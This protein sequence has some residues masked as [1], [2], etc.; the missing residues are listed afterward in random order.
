VLEPP[1]LKTTSESDIPA[2]VSIQLL[3]FV[4]ERPSSYEHIRQIQGYLDSVKTDNPWELQVIEIHE[5]PH[6]VEHFRLVATP[7]LV[8]VAPEPRQTLAGSNIVN[9]LKK[10]WPR[11]QI[12]IEEEKIEQSKNG[13]N[14]AKTSESLNSLKYS[15]E[16]MRLSDQIFRLNQ[17]KE[18]L[19]RQLK[20]KDQ[21]LA[22]L[23]HDLRSPLT[24]ASIAVETLEIAQNNQNIQR[25]AQLKEQLYQQARKQFRVMNSLITDMLQASKSLNGQLQVKYNQVFLPELCEE[26]LRQYQDRFNA[27]CLTLSQD[28]P[29][30]IPLVYGNAELIRQMIVN[31]L[32]NAIKYTPE[33]GEV[34][35]SILHRTTQKIQVSV[36]DT[37]PGIPEEK[38]ELIFEGHFR[39]K[40]DQEKEGYGLG[41]SLCRKIVRA[42]YGQIWVDS[43]LGQG[44]CFHFT[45]PVYR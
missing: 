16:L 7:A 4:D 14:I 1:N 42:H 27:K 24:A 3:L 20:F 28:L 13:Q 45:L 38:R 34:T 30:D 19:L 35:V 33:E 12:A 10:W 44:S 40:R 15:S 26:I 11:W 21:V 18:E 6:L 23:A 5:Q 36:C 43:I 8:K 39:L 32:D 2:P 31:L 37:G 29:Q 17:E 22:M 9:Q 41:L 25:H